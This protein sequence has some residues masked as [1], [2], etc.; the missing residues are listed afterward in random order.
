MH[1]CLLGLV[2]TVYGFAFVAE[3]VCTFY[4]FIFL[5]YNKFFKSVHSFWCCPVMVFSMCLAAIYCQTCFDLY[6]L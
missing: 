2:F 1:S 5:V 3:F 4:I 6:S